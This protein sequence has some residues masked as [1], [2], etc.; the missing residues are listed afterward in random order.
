[1]KNKR[2]NKV[3]VGLIQMKAAESPQINLTQAVRK[4]REAAE[5]GAQ[6]ISLSELFRTLYFPQNRS[7]DHFRLAEPVP[8]PTTELFRTLARELRVVI[9]VPIFE[10]RSRKLFYNTAAVID[11]DGKA[12]GIYRKT[13]LPNDPCF[14]EKFYFKPGD[15]G[16][17]SYQTR[18]GKVGV[19]ICWDQWFPEA[20]RLIALSGAQVL[21]YPT[22]IG[23]HG[24]EKK[25]TRLEERESWEIVQRAHAAE[26]GI[27]V[28]VANRVGREGAIH[29]WGG[30]FAVGPFGEVMAQASG[31]S[32]ETLIV[33]CDFSKINQVRRNWPFLRERRIDAY[34][35]ISN[36]L[37]EKRKLKS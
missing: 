26:N 22:A 27:Y 32:E 28:A 31:T 8:G 33:H 7:R 21:F 23:W 10:K 36:R 35:G 29:F 18:Y 15:L 19:L 24:K 16:F 25:E 34:G 3:T 37:D 6:I 1:M 13:H 30:S 11:A 2:G 14:Y 5:K 20:A 12:I 4:V 17:P 9:I